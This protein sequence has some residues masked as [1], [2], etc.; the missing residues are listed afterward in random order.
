[1][2]T[3]KSFFFFDL[4]QRI[5]KPRTADFCIK[6]R[7][8][9]DAAMLFFHREVLPKLTVEHKTRIADTPFMHLFAFPHDTHANNPVLHSILLN[10]D[11]KE[12]AFIFKKRCLKFTFQEVGMVMGLGVSGEAV[13][14]KK[15]RLEDTSFRCRHFR[16]NGRLSVRMLENAIRKALE[17]GATVDDV[18]GLLVM[19]I[20]SMV[21]FPLACGNV[22]NHLFHYASDIDNLKEYNWAEA[23]HRVLLDNIPNKAS[24]CRLKRA[25]E[26]KGKLQ[27]SDEE[28]DEEGELEGDEEEGGGQTKK[29]EKKESGTLPGCAI[30]LIVSLINS[31]EYFN[32]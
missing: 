4:G 13:E 23:V 20:F 25:E 5:R 2:N 14:Y 3:P 10:W 12:G 18:V 17:E 1:M 21:L 19:Y 11:D 7:C 6:N 16:R 8:N 15:G 9:I 31:D 32:I 27:A 29:K 28:E 26:T 24:W 30:A 22:P